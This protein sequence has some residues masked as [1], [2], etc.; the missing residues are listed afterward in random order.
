MKGV[1]L[2]VISSQV[3]VRS[4]KYFHLTCNDVHIAGVDTGC[5]SLI[6]SGKVKVKHG[7]EL[8]EYQTKGI[9]LS[10]GSTIPAD[11]VIYA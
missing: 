10:D 5:A 1:S 11:S 3:T 9:I 7:V 6:I 4:N 2:I 8:K